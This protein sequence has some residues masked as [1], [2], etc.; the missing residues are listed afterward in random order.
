MKKIAFASLLT[1][2]LFAL[3]AFGLEGKVS[4]QEIPALQYALDTVWVIF[5][6]VLVF[7]M[8]AGFAMVESGFT[9]AKNAS[10]IMMKNMMDFVIGSLSFYVIGFAVMF[11]NGTPFIG[12]EGFLPTAA[13][14]DS[15]SS[16]AWTSVPVLT[17]YFFQVVFAATAVTILSGAAAE[18][19]KFS[20]YLIISV[21]VT[22]VIYPVSGHWAW[23]GGWLSGLGFVDFAGSSVV[24]SVGGWASLAVVLV[25]GARLG[26]FN[27]A[28]KAMAIPGHNIPMATLGVFILW[29]GWYGFNPGSTMAAT[30]N[31][32]DIAVTT[33]LAGAAAALSAFI[34]TFM[35]YKR[36]DVGMTLNGALAGLV[37]I[38]AG[39][40]NVSPLGAIVIGLI[41]GILVVVSV[42]FFDKV[43]IDDPVGAISVHG[44]CGSTGTLLVGLFDTQKGLLYGGGID[45]LITQAIGVFSI[46]LWA[47]G[48]SIVLFKILD[49]VMG[50]R[51]TEE[52]EHVGLDYSE[53]GAAAY[54]D[55]N[56][57]S[58]SARN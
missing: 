1:L 26:K 38:T 21:L 55:F 8:Q 16:L 58:V 6:A 7:F 42:L 57:S 15:Y 24:H 3:P 9:R 41:V 47:F 44:V 48:S 46:A 17:A 31:I 29:F 27:A 13:Q 32:G 54:P 56:I 51:V 49:M 43:K 12:L 39:C 25:L 4:G 40:A 36:A 23:G 18:R 19:I 2:G 5:A 22:T 50:L 33:T 11:G 20:T 34:F 35:L 10:N 37:G 14:A 28:G 45:M 30:V 52:E 53:H